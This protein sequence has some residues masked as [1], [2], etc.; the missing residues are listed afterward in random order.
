MYQTS[1][2][3]DPPRAF[4][5]QLTHQFPGGKESKVAEGAGLVAG[6]PALRGTDDDQA[7][8]ITDGDPVTEATLLGFVMLETSRPFDATAMIADTDPVAIVRKGRIAVMT[9][10]AVTQGNPV[11]VGNATAQLGQ[12]DDAT[13]TGLVQAPG[14]RFVTST[15]G[16][17]IAIVEINLPAS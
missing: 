2:L 1:I 4:A 3:D 9:T 17:G 5:G 16:A 14:C 12:I 13:G 11:F 7:V 8:A 15:T 6:Q 10:A